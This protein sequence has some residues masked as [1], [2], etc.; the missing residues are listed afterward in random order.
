MSRTTPQQHTPS[1][2]L[3]GNYD[4]T[5]TTE[6]VNRRV[7]EEAIIDLAKGGYEAVVGMQRQMDSVM[8]HPPG[9]GKTLS[10]EEE[11]EVE[12]HHHHSRRR[13]K[14]RRKK[15]RGL[16][17]DGEPWNLF[18]VDAVRQI[19]KEGEYLRLETERQM[20]MGCGV[21]DGGEGSEYV[22]R[23]TLELWQELSLEEKERYL[24][25]S[26]C[27]STSSPTTAT[28]TAAKVKVKDHINRPH[29]KQLLQ[30]LSY[31]KKN[32]L[33]EELR[34]I[35]IPAPNR[36]T[37]KKL[38]AECKKRGVNLPKNYCTKLELL[39]CLVDR[40]VV[41]TTIKTT[42]PSNEGLEDNG[43]SKMMEGSEVCYL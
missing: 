18:K 37:K 38:L 15:Q 23:R 30:N 5:P 17:V 22:H 2:Q 35:G 42:P 27:G 7:E 8:G 6:E 25:L 14:K 16:R 32:K 4:S 20:M 43:T 31:D 1:S 24:E 10:T 21:D 13:R 19:I 40:A 39:Y 12:P 34:K 9:G 29:E 28:T 11:E 26:W 41:T 3:S 33:M 36:L